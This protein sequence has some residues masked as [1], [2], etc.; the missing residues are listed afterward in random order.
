MFDSL[1]LHDAILNSINVDWKGGICVFQLET[2]VEKNCLLV[3]NGLSQINIPRHEPWGAS[4][5]VNSLRQVGNSK[6]EI[7]I[8]SGDVISIFATDWAFHGVR[9]AYVANGKN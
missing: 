6:F 2:F 1:P 5:S 9:P 7:E 8:Q 3:F 4:I